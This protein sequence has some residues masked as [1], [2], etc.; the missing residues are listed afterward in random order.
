MPQDALKCPDCNSSEFVLEG[1]E[2][3]CA[4]PECK[5]LVASTSDSAG[6]I[7]ARKFNVEVRFIFNS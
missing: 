1:V 4:N 6:E 3:K 2:F 7:L 5:K